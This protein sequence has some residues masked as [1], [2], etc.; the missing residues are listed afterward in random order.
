MLRTKGQFEA[1]QHVLE[2]S[3]SSSQSTPGQPTAGT[4]NPRTPPTFK[5]DATGTSSGAS[6]GGAKVGGGQARR[7]SH[8]QP[9]SASGRKPRTSRS[10][11][12][13]TPTGIGS[14]DGMWTPGATPIGTTGE[15]SPLGSLGGVLDSYASPSMFGT[16]SSMMSSPA[17]S[18]LSASA[19]G[20]ASRLFAAAVHGTP[21]GTFA[22]AADSD[23]VAML[24]EEMRAALAV[25]EDELKEQRSLTRRLNKEVKRLQ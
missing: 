15:C 17:A 9:L 4:Q 20:K 22:D 18:L 1:L 12:S 16:M 25:V 11:V 19:S 24:R 23:P 21:T 5:I 3:T 10:Q 7:R 2:D 13:G 8:M 14:T 6:V